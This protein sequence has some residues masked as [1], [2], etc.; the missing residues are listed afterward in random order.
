MSFFSSY[1]YVYVRPVVQLRDHKRYITSKEKT[2]KNIR[3]KTTEQGVFPA[4]VR[5]PSS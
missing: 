3:N 2:P 1:S 4:L 5:S